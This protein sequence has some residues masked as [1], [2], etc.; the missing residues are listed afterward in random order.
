MSKETFTSLLVPT[1]PSLRNLLKRRLRDSDHAEDILQQALLMAFARRDQLRDQ[2][3]FKS[4]LWS[5][6]FNELRLFLR[7]SHQ[8]VSLDEFPH[9]EPPSTGFGPLAQYEQREKA[10]RVHA[11]MA[12]LGERDRIVIRLVDFN[13]LTVGEVA[14]K[15]AISGPAA[16]ST[17]YRAKRRLGQ[18]IRQ[19]V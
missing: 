7:R 18:A 13:G 10:D 19:A 1:L 11:G 6:A 4:W 12:A 3:K 16:K 5:I 17:H 14:A 15:L 2:A 8:D 9:L